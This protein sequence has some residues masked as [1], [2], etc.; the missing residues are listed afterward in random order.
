[1]EVLTD[2]HKEGRTILMVTHDSRMEKYASSVIYLMDG[3]VA[4]QDE[5]ML[6]HAS[7][8]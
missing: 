6:T 8:D 7:N 2:L 5:F 4:S 1:M 3:R